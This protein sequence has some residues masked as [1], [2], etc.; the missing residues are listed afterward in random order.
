MSTQGERSQFRRLI[1]DYAVNVVPDTE[2]E[3]YLDDATAEGS[4]QAFDTPITDYDLLP[5]RYSVETI[6]LAAINWWW[7]A[8]AKLSSRH[9]QTVGQA[10][11]G[12][13]EKWDRAMEMISRLQARY[14]EISELKNSIY[15]GN[16]SRFS[17]ST[18]TRIGGQEEESALD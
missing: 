16:N 10:Q 12:A 18:L 5:S 2:L 6:Y 8:A 11:Q 9:S 7:D 17:K 1:G 15:M 14:D 4:S 3:Y 13:S